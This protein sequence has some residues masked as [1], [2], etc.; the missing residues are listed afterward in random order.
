MISVV[1]ST[2]ELASPL[3]DL[4]Q[5]QQV[6]HNG[7]CFVALDGRSGSGKST[8]AAYVT[9]QLP[10]VTVIE[11]DEFYT[12]GSFNLWSSRPTSENAHC[13]VDW[14]HQHSVIASLRSKGIASWRA[15]DWHSEN[16]DSEQAPYC[17]TRTT[18]SATDIVLLEGVYSARTELSMLFDLR[19]V[20]DVPKQVRRKQLIDREG[21]NL[22]TD[23]AQVWLDAENYY[24]KNC[25]DYQSLSMVLN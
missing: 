18:C 19:V 23:W 7:P 25:L 2:A 16:W 20:L 13:C 8:L 3:L 1:K 5:N 11:G 21:N 4:I 22:R 24:F 9:S 15:F 17:A 14:K 10:S 6:Q 12:G